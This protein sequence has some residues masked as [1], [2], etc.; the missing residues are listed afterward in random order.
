MDIPEHVPT[1]RGP[2][3]VDRYLI[4]GHLWE[5]PAR[6]RGRPEAACLARAAALVSGW[7]AARP[8]PRGEVLIDFAFLLRDEPRTLVDVALSFVPAAA[9]RAIPARA[10]WTA[11]R[12]D[13]VVEVFNDRE[14]RAAVTERAWEY[15]AVGVRELW[16]IDPT[17]GDCWVDVVRAGWEP[18]RLLPR[19]SLASAVLPGFSCPVADLF[20]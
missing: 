15:A 10:W 9:A 18:S 17:P 14:P 5:R 13:L 20:R 7:A 19:Q 2:P 16:V 12:P 1:R 8:G 3:A 11:E 6:P 4:R